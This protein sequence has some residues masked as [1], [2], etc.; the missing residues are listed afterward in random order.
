M[1][2]SRTAVAAALLQL[3]T[4]ALAHGDAHNEA[5][6]GPGHGDMPNMHQEQNQTDGKEINN[7]DA[8]SYYGL[9]SHSN[10]M[11]AHIILMVSAWFFILPFGALATVHSH[12]A[13]LLACANDF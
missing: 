13:R 7:F 5:K 6:A 2:V 8:P 10:L 12:C 1:V 11:L 4:L 3:A 9:E